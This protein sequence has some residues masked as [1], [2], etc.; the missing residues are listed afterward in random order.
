MYCADHKED[1]SGAQSDDVDVLQPDSSKVVFN[2][3]S[4]TNL[5][6]SDCKNVL[7]FTVNVFQYFYYYYFSKYLFKIY[8]SW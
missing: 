6:D 4:S 1:C 5:N 7:R 8:L 3:D 2:I